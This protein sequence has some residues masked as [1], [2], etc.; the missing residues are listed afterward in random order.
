MKQRR[1]IIGLCEV[2]LAEFLRLPQG[3]QFIS[4]KVSDKVAGVIEFLVE[5][6]T[7]PEVQEG[8]HYSQMAPTVTLY[9]SYSKFSWQPEH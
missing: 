1:A 8:F 3:T 4:A 6:E 9:P 7:L 5:H 2:D